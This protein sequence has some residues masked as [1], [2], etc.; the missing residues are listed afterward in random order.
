MPLPYVKNTA[1]ILQVSTLPSGSQWPSWKDTGM[2]L[3]IYGV[4]IDLY[5]CMFHFSGTQS[6]RC[7]PMTLVATLRLTRLKELRQQRSMQAP[8]KDAAL[9]PP[10]PRDFAS[11][12]PEPRR[13]PELKLDL[14]IHCFHNGSGYRNVEGYYVKRRKYGSGQIPAFCV[15]LAMTHERRLLI[16]GLTRVRMSSY[17]TGLSVY[18]CRTIFGMLGHDAGTS[19]RA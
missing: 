7:K 17:G 1:L 11:F 15:P 16:Y 10:P 9:R 18:T 6:H 12:A 19:E 4:Y 3:C 8:L 5:T 14:G 2:Y 13:A